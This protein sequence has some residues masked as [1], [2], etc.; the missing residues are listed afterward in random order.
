MAAV[1]TS[2]IKDATFAPVHSFK[3]ISQ[4]AVETRVFSHGRK[5][6]SSFQLSNL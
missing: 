5:Q 6:P 2:R 4:L 1:T 3:F